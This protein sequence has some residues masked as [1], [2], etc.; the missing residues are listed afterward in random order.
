MNY[1][2][3]AACH[4]VQLHGS[5]QSTK[6]RLSFS[7]IV[8]PPPPTPHSS[9]N[10]LPSVHEQTITLPPSIMFLTLKLSIL[11]SE[12]HGHRLFNFLS[13]SL[14]ISLNQPSPHWR[15]MMS[16]GSLDQCPHLLIKSLSLTLNAS[17]KLPA[18]KCLVHH[19]RD[20]NTRVSSSEK[21]VRVLGGFSTADDPF[22]EPGTTTSTVVSAEDLRLKPGLNC[23]GIGVTYL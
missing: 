12:A 13:L 20:I 2:L 21:P 11:E 22:S 9:L 23:F 3:H 4:V 15:P 14:P 5:Y 6:A 19:N 16:G 1:L 10:L 7:V 17:T 8:T 18:I